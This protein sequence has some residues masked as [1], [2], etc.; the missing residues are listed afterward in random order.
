[1][2]LELIS[3]L[4]RQQTNGLDSLL[5]LCSPPFSLHPREALCP[6]WSTGTPSI[7]SVVSTFLPLHPV[8][9]RQRQ[10]GIL[11]L[12]LLKYLVYYT[13]LGI[14][15]CTDTLSCVCLCVSKPHNVLQRACWRPDNS[16]GEYEVWCGVT[17]RGWS[18][19]YGATFSEPLFS[20]VHGK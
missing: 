11:F 1:M 12:L 3:L 7:H 19:T 6:W 5:Y 10:E 18:Q 15:L 20:C 8:H 14:H 13:Y 16:G 17:L 9:E 4:G 2:L